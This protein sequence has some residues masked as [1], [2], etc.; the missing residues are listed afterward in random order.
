MISDSKTIIDFL[1]DTFKFGNETQNQLLQ[2]NEQK[3][4]Y[5]EETSE[6][7]NYLM[8]KHQVLKEKR[9]EVNSEI[10]N[11]KIEIKDEQDKL[12]QKLVELSNCSCLLNSS[13][14]VA[15]KLSMIKELQTQFL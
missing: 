3:R 5:L 12:K 13:K 15:S 10:S 9:N 1:I 7:L 11:L 8:N 6:Q 14:S 4:I 2:S